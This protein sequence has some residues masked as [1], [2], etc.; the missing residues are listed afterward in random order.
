MVNIPRPT[1]EVALS[2]PHGVKETIVFDPNQV[3]LKKAKKEN[4]N[5]PNLVM[6]CK[7]LKIV[8]A[9]PQKTLQVGG[10]QGQ[11]AV[12]Q[13]VKSVAT[14][15][16]VVFRTNANQPSEPQKIFTLVP[17]QPARGNVS[18]ETNKTVKTLAPVEKPRKIILKTRNE[19]DI[20]SAEDF[21]RFLL[22]NRL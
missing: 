12:Q 21:A 2:A 18:S 11:P 22:S 4:F 15:H 14:K 16:N 19:E 6:P 17:F 1:Q 10:G 3:T 7:N 13:P 20:V 9:P 5:N 8:S